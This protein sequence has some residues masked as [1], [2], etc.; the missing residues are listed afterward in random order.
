M[1]LTGSSSI[2][3]KIIKRDG[4]VVEFDRAKI[5]EA[6]WKAIKSVGGKDRA[7]AERLSNQVVERLGKQLKPGEIPHVEQ[8][9]DLVE[10]V[11]VENNLYNVAKTY[12]LY[13]ALHAQIREFVDSYLENK[14]WLVKENANTT[15]SLQALNFHISSQVISQYWLHRIFNKGRTEIREAHLN[16]DFHIHNLGILGPYCVGWD[17]R[18][19]LMT[20]FRGVRG[21]VSARPAKHFRVALGHVVNFVFT[22]QGEAA[23]AQAFSSFDT[24]L[25]PFIRYDNLDYKSVK[26]AIQEFMFNMNIPTRVG[27]Q[28]PFSNVTLDLRVP[29]FMKEEPVIIGGQVLDDT[30][31]D[32]QEEMNVFNRALAEVMLEGDAVGR[33]FTFPIPTINITRDFNWDD[34]T[35][36]KVLETSAKYGIPYFANFVNSDMNPEDVRSMCCHLRLDKRELKK[37]GGGLFGANPLTG[38]Y[39]ENTEILTEKGWKLFKDLSIRDRVF[40]L[41]ENNEIELHH[42]T[43]L[44]EYDY[45]GEMIHFKSRS[46]DLL[47]TPNHR[48]VVDAP[49]GKRMFVEA[50]DFNPNTH[51]IPKGGIWE[52]EGKEYFV[53]PS[54][55]ILQGN[56][57]ESKFSAEQLTVIRKLKNE[58]KSIYRLA[59]DFDCSPATVF[60][61]CN[62]G[63]YGNRERV[64]IKS[65][66]P[67]LKVKMNDW[68][69]FF[70][71][72]LAEG[73]TD[74]EKIAE[75][76]GYRVVI[77]QV[78]KKKREEIK[79]VLKKLPFNYYEEGTNLVICNKQLW[80]YLRQFGNKYTKFIPEE[81]KKLDKKQLK[82]LFDWMVKG[83]GYV[84]KTTGQIN[85]WTS[86]KK[87]ADDLQEIALKL[88]YLATITQMKKKISEIN[89]R[90]LVSNTV[91]VIGI[92]KSRHYRLREQ[93]VRK[94]RYHGK[95][96]CCEVKNHTVF[97]RRN[98]RVS[99]CGN[100]IGVVTINMPRIGFLSKS[101]GEFFA[102][103]DRIMVLAKDV[104][105]IKRK[106][107]EKFTEAGLYPYSRFYLRH[108]KESFGYYWKNHFSTIGLIGMNEACLNFLGCTIGDPEGL[109]FSIKVLDF[110]RKRLQDFQEETGNIFNLEATPAEGT[111]HRLARID[112]KTYPSIIVANEEEVKK[113]AAPYYTNSTHLPVYYTDDLWDY[114]RLQDPLQT[115]Y[116]GGTVVHVWL[117]ESN[118]PV[119]SVAVLVRKI[120]ENFKLPYFTLTPTFSICPEDG[121]LAGEQHTCPK[122]GRTAEVY[123]RVVGYLR[124]VEQ[125]N[126]GK[127]EEFKQRKVFDKAFT[128]KLVAQT[129]G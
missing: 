79:N 125:W 77:S 128:K 23:G 6:I 18:D 68:L 65:M 72:W 127:Q 41:T 78:D 31:G 116:T 74:K 4:R 92:Q 54:I 101:E 117:G 124:P 106:W 110:M 24:Y 120:C 113:G 104:L 86:S 121:Y 73:S 2:P 57:P 43:R 118:P 32:F 52:G 95:V 66:T 75:R 44:F 111:S 17:L 39:D 70:G 71:F 16:G 20:G 58:G 80:S 67:R 122:C 13:R 64:K 21:K 40:T 82:I 115:R 34:E 7:L 29:S 27:F 15:Y 38:C 48:M 53:L 30:Y 5:T 55:P 119:E 49:N 9:Q 42:P 3:S 35:V 36:R 99:W 46:L 107:L 51:R 94:I 26:Q 91:Y 10:K 103:L 19:L 84:R 85:Y 97:V 114:L 87:L 12:I 33:V 59:K 81:I 98:G 109:S 108:I 61:I 126:Q 47:V 37:R 112:R 62:D 60:N 88:G 89:G 76:H 45:D 1:S 8:V 93:N 123:S 90:Q 69:K 83:D 50:K 129:T 100:S 102:R 96:Y 22:L 28:T 63:G 25:A 56:G 105:E 11:L 14:S